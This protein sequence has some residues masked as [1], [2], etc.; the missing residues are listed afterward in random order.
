[1]PSSFV[2]I[3]FRKI[4]KD[5]KDTNNANILITEYFKTISVNCE[6]QALIV[7]SSQEQKI[8]EKPQ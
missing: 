3:S 2:M 5:Y 7:V 4:L 8:L 1:M 6:T